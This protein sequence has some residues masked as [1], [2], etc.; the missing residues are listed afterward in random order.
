MNLLSW[1]AINEVSYLKCKK[2]VEYS[3]PTYLG[4]E[5][6]DAESEIDDEATGAIK[7]IQL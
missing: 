1:I 3:I 7:D 2:S 4:S 5:R 6:S